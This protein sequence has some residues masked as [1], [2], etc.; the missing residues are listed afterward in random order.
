MVGSSNTDNGARVEKA[1]TNA[2]YSRAWQG[3][4]GR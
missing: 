4:G 1:A 2:I 3:M